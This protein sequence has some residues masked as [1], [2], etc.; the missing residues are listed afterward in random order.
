MDG[1]R[2]LSPTGKWTE[3][4]FDGVLAAVHLIKLGGIAVYLHSPGL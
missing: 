3:A 2:T 1:L 4:M